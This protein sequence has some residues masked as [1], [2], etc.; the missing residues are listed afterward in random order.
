MII[1]LTTIF[2]ST[3]AVAAP[4]AS[5]R[6]EI[7]EVFGPKEV[8]V[9][10]NNK[11]KILYVGD[12]VFLGNTIETKAKQIVQLEAFDKSQWKVAPETTLKLEKRLAE[13]KTLSYWVFGLVK[14]YLWGKVTPH[15]DKE[16]FR[17]KIITKSAAMGI[18]GTEYLLAGDQ[19]SEV[20]VLEGKVWWG[21]SDGF[22]EGTYQEVKAGEHAEAIAR[23][24]K[25][26]V[27]STLKGN[28]LLNKYH[29]VL[30]EADLAEAAKM[31]ERSPEDCHVRAEGW[32]SKDGTS[33][34]K[35]Y[36]ADPK[37]KDADE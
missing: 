28:D 17:Q 15:P 7:R 6:I 11:E 23:E 24:I 20:D 21:S 8:K 3:F 10:I 13:K 2:S 25:K 16:G 22:E 31:N 34:G 33:R 35:C 32:K 9:L 14:G 5:D 30:S 37:I 1:I 26:P 36:R 27:P 29:L 18:R 19:N 4:S 12:E